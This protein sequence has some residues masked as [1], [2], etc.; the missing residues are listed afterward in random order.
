MAEPLIV[1]LSNSQSSHRIRCGSDQF[2]NGLHA[3]HERV[4][5]LQPLRLA[6]AT[7]IVFASPPFCPRIPHRG[8]ILSGRPGWFSPLKLG[9]RSQPH[10]EKAAFPRARKASKLIEFLFTGCSS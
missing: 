1:A 3:K 5:G 9:S 4:R 7:A 2:A 8:A 10:L 6:A